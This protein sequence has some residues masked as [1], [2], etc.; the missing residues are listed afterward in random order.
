MSETTKK[1]E[2]IPEA[3]IL[4]NEQLS[5]AKKT[6]G[7]DILSLILF[8][9]LIA[10]AAIAF[11]IIPD[12]D[13]SPEEKRGLQTFP[14]FT[15]ERFKDD[16]KRDFSELFMTYDE[17]VASGNDSPVFFDEIASYY[18]DQFPLRNTL[19]N[20]KAA[21][22]KALV[23][24][25]NNN[26]VY[27]K[28][29][30]LIVK[31]T[32]TGEEKNSDGTS[33]DRTEDDAISQIRHNV[34]VMNAMKMMLSGT[35]KKFVAAIPGRGIDVLRSKLPSFYPYEDTVEPY[36]TAYNDASNK[37]GLETV[38]LR[39]TLTEH[40]DNGEYVYYKTD[41][42]WTGDGVYYAYVEL[43]KA[44]GEAPADKSV[45]RADNVSDE[46]YGTVYSKS[47]ASF[48][49]GDTLTLYRYDGDENYTTKIV[50]G[51]E[52]QEYSGFYNFK[53]LDEVDKYSVFIGHDTHG[54]NNPLT[55]VTKNTDEE[56]ETLVL[57]KDSFG[58]SLV[59][60]L[61]YHYDLIIVDMRYYE[62]NGT[63]NAPFISDF[64]SREN[65]VGMLIL[66]NMETFMNDKDLQKILS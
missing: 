45:F 44:L 55:Y 59:P 61:A 17:K 23:K 10:A 35:D 20:I 48:V 60:L 46:F 15:V 6:R 64:M 36:W 8:C 49:G 12:K 66:E 38:D 39:Q 33:R 4:L 29:S 40:A 65:V 58:H 50:N 21:S 53:Y 34:N 28:D 19:R 41:H 51:T 57:V 11:W 9:A 32:V 18:S 63:E 30:Y 26:V 22:E 24:L 31:D 54:G 43:M 5:I 37:V 7:A 25:E 52:V 16:F 62:P 42:H 56:R 13:Y 47:G 3:E 2:K 27:G 1:Q 14:E